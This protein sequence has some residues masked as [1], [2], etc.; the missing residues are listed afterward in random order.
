MKMV[1]MA[2]GRRLVELWKTKSIGELEYIK[3]KKP[4]LADFIDEL[5]RQKLCETKTKGGL[6]T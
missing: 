6:K 4:E 5:I 1:S 3:R 2:Q